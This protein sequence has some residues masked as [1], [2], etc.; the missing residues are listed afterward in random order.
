[1]AYRGTALTYKIRKTTVGN[2]TGENYSITIPTFIAK[3]FEGFLF[4]L[5]VSGDSIIFESGCKMSV[6]D[7]GINHAKKLFVGGR[8]ISFK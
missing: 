1:M 7:I 2:K 4:R 3:K 8:T 6:T 5:A